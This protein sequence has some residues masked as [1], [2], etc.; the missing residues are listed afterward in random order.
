MKVWTSALL[1]IVA[2]VACGCDT[3]GSN[4]VNDQNPGAKPGESPTV[5]N[6]PLSRPK[7][8][9]RVGTYAGEWSEPVNGLSARLLVT[10]QEGGRSSLWAG[11]IIL[12]VKNTDGKPIAFINQPAFTGAAVRDAI[13]NA[14]PEFFGPGNHLSG[15]PQWAV[16]PGNAYLGMRVDTSIPVEV[17][18]CF[19]V[20]TPDALHLS[21][22]LVA[23]HREGPENQW[24]GEIKL[25]PVDLTSNGPGIK[26]GESAT[27]T[28]SSQSEPNDIPSAGTYAGKWSEPI[29]GLSA[30][31]LVT[32]QGKRV[33][34]SAT[35]VIL[36]V[37]NLESSPRSFMDQPTF[38]GVAV[39]EAIGYALPEASLDGNL[40]TPDP[41]WA[42]IPGNAYLGISVDTSIPV[43]FGLCFGPIT[44]GAHHLNATLV[45]KHREGPKDQWIGEIALPP[46]VL[47]SGGSGT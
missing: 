28:N 12:E 29:N 10:F 30:R 15:Y 43:H 14:L 11:P 25:P 41:Q 46:V 22:T 3:P 7:A 42:V 13:G 33:P 34:L 38:T 8:V 39:R 16:I 40:L 9:P 31:L 26:P 27:V 23:K 6:S 21:A 32:L 24:V 5:V 4:H 18:L 47:T 17:G 36:E 37:R 1:V 45:A 35:P 20:I 2:T 44:P 19:G